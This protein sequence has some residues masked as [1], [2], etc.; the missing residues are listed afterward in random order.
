[1]SEI[2]RGVSN[3]KIEQTFPS[4][5]TDVRI[6]VI[7]DGITLVDAQAVVAAGTKYSYAIP[8]EI[9]TY[10]GKFTAIWEMSYGGSTYKIPEEH[11]VVTPLMS[12]NGIFGSDLTEAKEWE[13]LVRRIV[14]A[15][16]RQSFGFSYG[17]KVVYG[18]GFDFIELP[19]RIIELEEVKAS[20][21]GS[22]T[23]DALS[24]TAFDVDETGWYIRNRPGSAIT[25]SVSNP[26]SYE[27]NGGSVPYPNTEKVI[28]PPRKSMRF[29]HNQRFEIK[30]LW[31]YPTPPQAVQEAFEI[32]YQDYK[33]Q[34]ATYRDR[35]IK[36]IRSG[37]W[38]IEFNDLAFLGTGS[39]QADQLLGEF[40]RG[41]V[42]VV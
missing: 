27:L 19:Q 9:Y 6:T 30:G 40:R 21:V 39:K 12:F 26:G 16:T 22:E 5:T 41:G 33:C 13:R 37:D 20:S 24:L 11:E 32:L 35:Y 17:T 10:D 4:G 7:R 28:Y 29:E 38:S 23:T 42:I 3:A 2:Y 15:Y 25:V 36:N 31:G 18:R 34:D 14:E 1:M 8:F